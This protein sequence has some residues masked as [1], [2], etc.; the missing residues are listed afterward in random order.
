MRIAQ[1]APLFESVPP[2]HYGGTERIVAYLTD[3]LV[4]LGHDVTLFASGESNTRARLVSTRAQALWLDPNRLCS[5][6]A[7]HMTMLQEV[8]RRADQFDILHFHLSHFAHFPFFEHMAGRTVTTPHGRLDYA[9]LPAAYDGWPRFPMI[10]ISDRQRLPLDRANW[11]ATVYHGLP[12][13]LYSPP[14]IGEVDPAGRYLA[15]LGRLSRTKRPDRAV[16]IARQSGLKLKIAAKID[17][18]DRAYFDNEVQPRIDGATIDYIGEIGDAAK[19]DFLGRAVA[20]LFPI[21]WP[22]PFGLAVIEAM[23]CGTPVIA[24]DNGAMAEIIDD[25]VTG[26]VVRSIDEAVAAVKLAPGLDRTLIRTRFEER[27]SVE[28]M[29]RNYLKAYRTVVS[30]CDESGE[31]VDPDMAE[32]F[33]QFHAQVQ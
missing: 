10:S 3:A 4:G 15:F 28:T 21:D 27:F 18:Q 8:R 20:L 24:W 17:D 13:D 16:D 30:R 25:G 33:R 5:P 12:R 14:A 29:A 32:K 6:I 1:I 31:I 23:A 7:A 2:T 26:Y 9:D 19:P 22:E 11:V